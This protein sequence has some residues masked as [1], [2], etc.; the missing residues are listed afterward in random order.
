MATNKQ[1]I[2][3]VSVAK[4]AK[5]VEKPSPIPTV[6]T[7]AKVEKVEKLDTV[8][9]EEEKATKEAEDQKDPQN[10]AI[11]KNGDVSVNETEMSD[12]S[13]KATIEQVK[14]MNLTPPPAQ[15]E[16]PKVKKYVCVRNV[17]SGVKELVPG[18]Q[19]KGSQKQIDRLLELGSIKE[20]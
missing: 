20:Q 16:K 11:E 18:D 2:P 10:V 12:E 5:E 8:E 13:V 4:Q 19:F 15:P 14:P 3:K 17:R 7:M 1:N 6:S 9:K